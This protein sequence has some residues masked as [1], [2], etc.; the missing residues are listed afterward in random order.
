MS[1]AARIRPARTEDVAAAAA[2]YAHYVETTAITFDLQVPTE[3][4]WRERLHAA[5]AAGHPWM[6]AVER[7]AV[8]GYA[9]AGT[10]NAKRAY[11]ATVETTV[12]LTPEATGR[13]WGSAL[14]GALLTE[15]AARSFH[16]AVALIA[17]PNPA[18]VA[19]HEALGFRRVGVLAE[20][21]H[22]L[23]VWRDVALWQLR[24][25]G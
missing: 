6:V 1:S 8:L 18:S 21:G 20:V 16:L 12:Y 17:L 22:K 4:D 25:D 15:C 2:I 7:G 10:F 9:T 14:Y 19:L 13:G 3:E 5:G 23:G 24:L 11:A